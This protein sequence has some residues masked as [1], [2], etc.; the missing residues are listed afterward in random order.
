MFCLKTLYSKLEKIHRKTLKVIFESNDTHDNL[1]LQSNTVSILQRKLRFLMTDVYKK[2]IAIKPSFY[3]VLF[4]KGPTPGLP[5][6]HSFCYGANALRFLVS[7]IWSSLPA[8]G[9]KV[10]H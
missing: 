1:L 3:V 7:L 5:K 8:V 6:T 10:Q 9:S 4:Q 2:Y